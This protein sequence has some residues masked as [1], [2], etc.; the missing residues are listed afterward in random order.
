MVVESSVRSV[1][2]LGLGLADVVKQR[3]QPDLQRITLLRGV[4]QGTDMV[5]K[6]GIDMVLVLTDPQAFPKLGQDVAQKVRLLKEQ[7]SG[8]RPVA[9]DYLQELVPDTFFGDHLQ[10]SRLLFHRPAGVHLDLEPQFRREAHRA[11]KAQGILGEA[12]FGFADRADHS[13]PQVLFASVGIDNRQVRPQRHGVHREIPAGQVLPDRPGEF[14]RIGVALVRISALDTI[15]G[16]LRDLQPG[17][18]GTGFDPHRAELVLVHGIREESEDLL[19]LGVGRDIPVLGFPVQKQV[20]YATAH[21]VRLESRRE[22]PLAR[23]R[24][25]LRN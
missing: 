7:H 18:L 21:Q 8:G 6:H 9:H 4:I 25:R 22:K 17:V 13:R 12:L 15:G 11:Q 3:G 24:Y 19:R 23:L 20:P 5:L 10:K 2:F 1:A 14:H 16:H